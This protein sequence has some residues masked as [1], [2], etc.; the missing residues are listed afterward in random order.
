MRGGQEGQKAEVL[1]WGAERVEDRVRLEDVW[2]EEICL[3][4]EVW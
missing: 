3:E 2:L 4:E 1:G